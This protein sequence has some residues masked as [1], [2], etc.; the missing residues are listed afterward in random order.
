MAQV[1]VLVEALQVLVVL[2]EAVLLGGSE[3]LL[4]HRLHHTL[5]A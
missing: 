4:V 1:A 3:Q 5:I 2:A